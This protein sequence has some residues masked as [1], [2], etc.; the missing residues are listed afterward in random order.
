M[1]NSL[2]KY[3]ALT[4]TIENGSFT[5]AAESMNYAQSSVSKMI[6]D[7]EREWGMA[8]LERSKNGVSLT[9]SGEQI[10]PFVRRLLHEYDSLEEQIQRMKGLET[11]LVRIGTFASVAINILP[12][13]FAQLK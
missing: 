4:K 3:Y 5:A 12:D 7:L 10:L 13:V 2:L 8:L 11:G 9:T 1:E 6:A